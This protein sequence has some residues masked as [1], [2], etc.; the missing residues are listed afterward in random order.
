MKGKSKGAYFLLFPLLRWID[1]TGIIS[2]HSVGW[3]PTS[4]GLI[5]QALA[6]LQASGTTCPWPPWQ[7]PHRLLLPVPHP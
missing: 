4:A 5:Q 3:P 2:F 1:L 6:Y 7:Q